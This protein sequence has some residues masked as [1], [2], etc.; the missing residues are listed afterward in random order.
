M[1][2]SVLMA[3]TLLLCRP[4][5]FRWQNSSPE[6]VTP[7]FGWHCYL[8]GN[9]TSRQ[10]SRRICTIHTGVR[11]SALRV[12]ELH[13]LLH[14]AAVTCWM[15]HVDD[16]RFLQHTLLLKLLTLLNYVKFPWNYWSVEPVCWQTSLMP[17]GCKRYSLMR[18]T[19]PANISTA[20]SGDS[21]RRAMT[22][23]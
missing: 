9:I 21:Y 5:T 17:T 12:S 11:P 3:H 8:K 16:T 13:K 10:R 18:I 19:I 23:I 7:M 2:L 1:F 20:I 6:S 22:L 14:L 4:G 15:W